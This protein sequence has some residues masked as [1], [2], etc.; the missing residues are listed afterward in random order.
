MSKHLW[1]SLLLHENHIPKAFSFVLA[2]SALVLTIPLDTLG[3]E[4]KAQ[5]LEQL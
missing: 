5:S 3:F 1:Q 4:L 2:P